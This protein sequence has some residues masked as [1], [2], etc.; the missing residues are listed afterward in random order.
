[1]FLLVM[2]LPPFIVDRIKWSEP[3]VC[4]WTVDHNREFVVFVALA[5]YHGPSVIMVICY[6]KVYMVMRKSKLALGKKLK[7]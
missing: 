2:W 5:G 7:M 1:M 6:V 4:M 3:G